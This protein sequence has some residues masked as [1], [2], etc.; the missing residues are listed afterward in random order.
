MDESRPLTHVFGRLVENH[1][2]DPMGP[3]FITP[4]ERERRNRLY[5]NI[6]STPDPKLRVGGRNKKRE[7]TSHGS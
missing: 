2:K 1:Y 3:R 7:V 5:A 4:E 6:G